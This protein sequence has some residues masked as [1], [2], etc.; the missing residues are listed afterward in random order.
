MKPLNRRWVLKRFSA[1][2]R[3]PIAQLFAAATKSLR[4]ILGSALLPDQVTVGQ[5]TTSSYEQYWYSTK[6]GEYSLD[7]R[8]SVPVVVV[9]VLSDD[10]EAMVS[11]TW[12]IRVRAIQDSAFIY[13]YPIADRPIWSCCDYKSLGCAS[14]DV[15]FQ[16][17]V[18][19]L[20]SLE[21]LGLGEELPV[22]WD[23]HGF[24]QRD[25]IPD[26]SVLVLGGNCIVPAPNGASKLSI[27]F[28]WSGGFQVVQA[29]ITA[30]AVHR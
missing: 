14:P 24:K 29:S 20:E 18:V 12:S 3:K 4:D 6:F 13:A 7:Q 16:F 30:R 23:D 10:Y 26:G 11:L 19:D 2:V 25:L 9:S 17:V 8:A 21:G 22:T 27:G 28:I 5:I 1:V 15:G